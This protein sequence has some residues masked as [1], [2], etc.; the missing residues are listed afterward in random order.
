MSDARVPWRG[1]RARPWIA[2]ILPPLSWY[3]FEVGLSSA[4]R[5]D[6]RPVGAWLGLAWGIGSLLACA[7]A[8][9]LAWPDAR[10]ADD[11][12]A[13][14]LWLARIALLLAAVFALPIMFQTLGVLIVPPCVR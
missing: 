4:L 14:R 1:R 3:L 10:P 12:T 5:V 11:Q 9:A 2:L 8:A 13:P 6:C 7:M